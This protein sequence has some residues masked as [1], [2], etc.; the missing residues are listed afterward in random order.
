MS[1]NP[2]LEVFDARFIWCELCEGCADASPHF[3][4]F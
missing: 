2:K 3:E 4:A 1:A